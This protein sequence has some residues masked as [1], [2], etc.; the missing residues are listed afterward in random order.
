VLLNV[1]YTAAAHCHLM[2][3]CALVVKSPVHVTGLIPPGKLTGTWNARPL[4][5][6][7]PPRLGS[8]TVSHVFVVVLK[9]VVA[10]IAAGLN[11]T[12]ASG[13]LSV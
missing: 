2:V 13:T 11:V 5:K 8:D 6:V 4:R 7:F 3:T 9:T 1:V 10:C 12:M